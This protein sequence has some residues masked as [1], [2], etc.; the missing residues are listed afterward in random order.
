MLKLEYGFLPEYLNEYKGVLILATDPNNITIPQ[1]R[2]WQKI[3]LED[4]RYLQ[5]YTLPRAVCTTDNGEHF[6]LID[7]YH[8]IANALI[9]DLSRVEVV[10]LLLH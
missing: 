4:S 3:K 6:T 5:N 7:G 2:Y 1:E 8:R 9:N 10:A